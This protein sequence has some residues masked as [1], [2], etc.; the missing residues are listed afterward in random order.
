MNSV[1]SDGSGGN[2]DGLMEGFIDGKLMSSWG[3]IKFRNHDNI[4]IDA[5][6]V[7]SF[8]GGG[9][10]SSS[11]RNEWAIF[12]D[13]YLFTY[14]DGVDVPRGRQQ[15]PD[16]RNLNLP[17]VK[18]ADAPPPP[19]S[20]VPDTETPETPTNIA[21]NDI[22]STS[23][24][25][26]W[27]ASTDNTGVTGY[28]VFVDFDQPV[29][30]TS[31]T[32]YILE[33]LIPGTNYVMNVTAFDAAG[34]ES[35][36]SATVE[37]ETTSFDEEP[38]TVPDGLEV[39]S[40][41]GYSIQYEWNPS[42]D[43]EG[44]DIYRIFFDDVWISDQPGTGYT[45]PNL[46]PDTEYKFNVQAFDA[47][48][49]FSAL[50]D[51]IVQ[52]TSGPD[53]Q[54]P[55]RPDGVEP[56]SVTE[57]TI[58]IQWN[59]STDNIGVEQ[60][61]IYL[62]NALKETSNSTSETLGLLQPGLDYS[63]EVSAVDEAGNESTRS[64][65]IIVTTN[66]D[67]ITT[68]PSLP[69]VAI[70]NIKDNTIRPS[71]VSQL[72]SLGFTELKNYGIEIYE[73]DNPSVA[74]IVLKGLETDSVL[75]LG[76]STDGLEVLYNFAEGEGNIVHDISGN[77]PALDLL[78]N[79]E[80]VTTE[81]LTG[82]GLR[83]LGSTI[84]EFP[85]TPQRLTQSLAS[86]NEIT[87]EAWVKQEQIEQS[88]PARIFTLSS[89][90]SARA[91]TLGHEGNKAAFD[92]VIRLNTSG[93]SVNGIPE[94]I[95]ELEFTTH[96]LHHVVFTRDTQGDEKIYI[97][98]LRLANG[99]RSGDFSTW[100]DDYHLAIGNEIDMG[101]PWIGIIYLAAIYNRAIRES[102]VEDNYE[103]GFGRIDFVSE[104][105]TLS[106]NTSYELVP[107]V[108]TDQGI[109]YGETRDFIYKNVLLTDS[110][111]AIYPNPND[112]RFFIK[113]TNNDENLK[114]V[115]LR[116]AD[117]TGQV[118]Y[119]DD[120]DFSEGLVENNFEILLPPS[121]SDGMYSIMLIAGNKSVAEKMVLLR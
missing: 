90:S 106:A 17:W 95:T 32:S 69:N 117:F 96:S 19:L 93:S 71:S 3:G 40:F 50:S 120:L 77:E 58:S 14:T 11:V 64:A 55:S 87:L 16:G 47:A 121:L 76:R 29:T 35:E 2:A 104:L 25:L 94:L 112:G 43:N 7:Y 46:E 49:N 63:L 60:Y 39:V 108:T 51:P 70:S 72:S 110:F 22:G 109:V 85:G 8:F 99:M 26:T 111:M 114:S 42:S 45:A 9:A 98:G 33:E 52:T 6:K 13:F 80:G 118:H 56:T 62:N 75:N 83:I 27:D 38:P 107:F 103:S 82:Q 44:V 31:G 115:I 100:D 119:T 12:D 5:M 61:L 21:I 15:S 102:E 20:E 36:R 65:V 57:T 41:S 79:R 105:D 18:G 10:N 48:G 116:I 23:M 86:S 113:V 78:I 89:G 53:T 37:G 24:T 74:P 73:K 81:W 34:N 91:V 92:Y 88:G 59:A 84:L 68:E 97:N 101:R 4:G 67:D 66:N 54:P 30:V 1:N 28:R